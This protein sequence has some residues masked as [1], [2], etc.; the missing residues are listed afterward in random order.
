[1]QGSTVTEEATTTTT[2]ALINTVVCFVALLVNVVT[3]ITKNI[4]SV[5][6]RQPHESSF[7]LTNSED[8]ILSG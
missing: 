5:I 1:M 4:F 7:Y 6:P 3:C 8:V 2:W